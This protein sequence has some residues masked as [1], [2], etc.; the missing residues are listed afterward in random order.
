MS[1]TLTRVLHS[2]LMAPAHSMVLGLND[3][4]PNVGSND[5]RS[6]VLKMGPNKSLPIFSSFLSL[7][8][9]FP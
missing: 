7:L 9:P 3:T 4:Q 5:V 2:L 8:F 1:P 6:S